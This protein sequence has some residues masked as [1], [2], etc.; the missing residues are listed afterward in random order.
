MLNPQNYN[1]NEMGGLQRLQVVIVD[2]L[3]IRTYFILMVI[4][5]KKDISADNIKVKN[6]ISFL[7]KCMVV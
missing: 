5:C 6:V 3:D 7:T 2:I 1:S 4:H